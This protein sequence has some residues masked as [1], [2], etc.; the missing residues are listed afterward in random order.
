MYLVLE[1]NTMQFCDRFFH[2]IKGT[3]MGT[4]MALSY[5]NLFM[6]KFEKDMLTEYELQHNKKPAL[7]LRF[8]DDIFMVWQGDEASLKTFLEFCNN[9]SNKH[10][11]K[12]KIRFTYASSVDFCRHVESC[13]PVFALR[14]QIQ[15]YLL[16]R[17]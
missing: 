11:M 6:G 7:W 8:I 15:L 4:P 5:A 1:S 17:V 2:Q 9:F 12:S 14:K 10:N 3:A 13:S 16:L